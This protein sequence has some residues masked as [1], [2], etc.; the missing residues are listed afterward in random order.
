MQKTWNIGNTTVRN[1][2]RIDDALRVFLN[3]GFSGNAKGKDLEKGLHAKLKDK[4][5]LYFD[6][7]ASDWNGRKWRAAFY[8]LG[9]IS[10]E[11][12]KLPSKKLSV[13][14]LF[15]QIDLSSIN[16]AYQLTPSGEKVVC[17]N[18]LHELEEVFIRQFC[19]YEI[20]S[21]LEPGFPRGR[22]KPF[23]LFLEVLLKLQEKSL[24]GLTKFETGLFIQK[25][26]NHDSKLANTIIKEITE[27]R[28]SLKLCK[29]PKATREYKEKRL[30]QLKKEIGINPKSVV[31]DYAD[32]TFRYFGLS[33]LL[34]HIGDRITIRNN[35]INFVKTLI[36]KEPEFTYSN[37][38]TDYL[39]KFYKN[40]YKIPTDD[41]FVALDEIQQLQSKIQDRKNIFVKEA[42]KV[43]SKSSL[44][45]VQTLRYQLIEYDSW[46]LEQDY[47]HSLKA[48]E[49]TSKTLAYLKVLNK[50][51]IS[52][53]PNIDDKPAYLEWAVWR[54]LLAINDLVCKSHE[55]RRFPVDRD[56]FPRSTAPGGG[57]DLVIEYKEF[58]LIVEVTLTI[59]H[60][61]LAAESEPVRRH[62]AQYI[63]HF[64]NKKVVCLFIAPEIDNN[65]LN[66]FHQGVWWAGDNPVKVD[67]VPVNLTSFIDIFI[68]LV[69]KKR[70]RIDLLELLNSCLKDRETL[71]VPKWKK[72]ISSSIEEW[73]ENL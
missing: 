52:N 34:T 50:E 47:A 15:R 49:E 65:T 21:V 24:P 11:Q 56:F 33:G 68:T 36:K 9:F 31:G 63:K 41:I 61:Q 45:S 19:C 62:V 28:L 53:P 73:K 17:S 54:A 5:V 64:Q 66:F 12:Y 18:T 38:P 23:I 59:S 3:E 35:K 27:Y 67:V 42:Q 29:T 37:S 22:M 39:A 16:S 20:P 40:Q 8:Q 7:E 10:Y 30:K 44:K 58:V 48:E 71:S 55:S 1:P 13:T 69:E 43:N 60:R 2:K 26:R 46:E 4:G 14:E 51:R 25:F 70:N 6:G 72:H 57:A 32:T